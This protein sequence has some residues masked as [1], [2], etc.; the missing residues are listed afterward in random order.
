MDRV[1][2]ADDFLSWLNEAEEELKKERRKD[3][4][5]DKR[6]DGILAAT[7]IVREYV[8][9]MCK[10][11]SS[12]NGSEVDHCNGCFG[13]ANGDCDECRHKDAEEYQAKEAAWIP[14]PERMPEPGGI[15]VGI[16][17]K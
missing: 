17:W 15:C 3:H 6:D 9:K 7:E 10:V 2:D 1:L 8:E 16:V 13:A 12:E 14:V 5:I 11:E 4:Q